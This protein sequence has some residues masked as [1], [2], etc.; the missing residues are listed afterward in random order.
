MA[1]VTSD[2][3]PPTLP[4]LTAEGLLTVMETA[5]QLLSMGCTGLEKGRRHTKQVIVALPHIAPPAESILRLF[6]K[7]A[8]EDISV[9]I[10][11]VTN[12]PQQARAPPLFAL[13]EKFPNCD[14]HET[15]NS[16]LGFMRLF[17]CCWTS[18]QLR[19]CEISLGDASIAC[20]LQPAVLPF[21][22]ILRVRV[23]KCH[24]VEVACEPDSICMTNMS[25]A[26]SEHV[27]CIPPYYM[28][29]ISLPRLSSQIVKM[30]ATSRISVD[31][32]DEGLFVGA[33]MYVLPAQGSHN[34]TWDEVATM[35][36]KMHSLRALL[37]EGG[38]CLLVETKISAETGEIGLLTK[39]Y[40]LLPS[41]G[42]CAFLLRVRYL[43]NMLDTLTHNLKANCHPR[44]IPSS[45]RRTG[46]ERE[47]DYQAGNAIATW[48][49]H[50][51]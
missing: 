48:Q 27:C 47:H 23:C 32:L 26:T 3:H 36:T 17:K 51:L 22:D 40:V 24:A 4:L 20:V 7:L 8:V 21:T 28:P 9:T 25:T 13:L 15:E 37:V 2:A 45:L 16:K 5:M 11:H 34:T 42:M 1:T 6:E 38:E 43:R 29:D 31:S 10:A 19:S 44:A 33:S 35:R 49:T 41:T 39:K 50:A 30:S 12:H 14:T 46:S 18:V